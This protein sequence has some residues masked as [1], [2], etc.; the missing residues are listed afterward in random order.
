MVLRAGRFCRRLS[1]LMT[2]APP[3]MKLEVKD[4]KIIIKQPCEKGLPSVGQPY[5]HRSSLGGLVCET[6]NGA[7]GDQISILERIFVEIFISG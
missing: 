4:K 6:C 1:G 5:A 2:V 7:P 3:V